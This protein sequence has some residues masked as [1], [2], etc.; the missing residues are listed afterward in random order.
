M[1]NR[2]GTRACGYIHCQKT[3]RGGHLCCSGEGRRGVGT[4]SPSSSRGGGGRPA[5]DRIYRGTVM[6]MRAGSDVGKHKT[7]AL[8]GPHSTRSG[9]GHRQAD[10]A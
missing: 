6:A 2:P 3:I 9:D 4:K 7:A 1:G 5:K 8:L 10:T